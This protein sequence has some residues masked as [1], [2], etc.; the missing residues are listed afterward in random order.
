[1]PIVIWAV[2][3]STTFFSWLESGL[4][5]SS[6]VIAVVVFLAGFKVALVIEDY[7]EVRHAP[8]LLQVACGGWLVVVVGMVWVLYTFPDVAAR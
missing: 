2:L 1:M 7:M 3:V 6:T 8:R 4:S 5:A